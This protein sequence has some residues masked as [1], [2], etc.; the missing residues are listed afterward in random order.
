MK[1]Q[2][3]ASLTVFFFDDNPFYTLVQNAQVNLQHCIDGYDKSVLLKEDFKSVGQ[4]KP[5]VNLKPNMQVFLNQIVNLTNEGFFLDIYVFAHGNDD[6]IYFDNGKV[7]TSDILKSELNK[8]KTGHGEYPIR[9]VYQVNCYGRTFNQ[10][11]L[12]LGAKVVC[13][14][15]WVNFYPNQFNKFA[16]NWNKGDVSFDQALKLSNTDSSRTVMQSLIA[17]DAMSKFN[18]EKC[19]LG[20]TVLGDHPCARSYFDKNWL[21]RDE[22]QEGQSGAENMNY[23]S[24]MFRPG[25]NDLTKKNMDPLVWHP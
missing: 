19:P 18:F 15:R 22:W 4:T 12:S 24:F 23:S 5:T 16:V 11:W 3:Q 17:S 8:S 1:P 6:K 7:L 20:K 21:A 13:G 14:P 9:I 10:T 2:K 25:L